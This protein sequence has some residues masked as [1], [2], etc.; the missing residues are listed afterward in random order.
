MSDIRTSKRLVTVLRHTAGQMNIDIDSNGFVKVS[1]LLGLSE[2]RHLTE[3]DIKRIA[4]NDDKKRF[5]MKKQGGELMIRANQGHSLQIN[6]N[7][8]P[9]YN[10]SNFP[11]VVHG[12]RRHAWNVISRDGLSKMGRMHI[13]FAIGEPGDPGVV[14]GMPSSSDII[15]YL[16]LNLALRNGLKFFV[17][18]NDV[19]LTEG[20]ENGFIKP[21]YFQKVIDRKTRCLLTW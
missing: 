15:I 12:T 20:D 2:F 17:S 6:L 14:S 13:H 9:I 18:E 1:E 10:G 4:N 19:I 5:F 16:N 3:S 21:K 7:L 11:K 8:K